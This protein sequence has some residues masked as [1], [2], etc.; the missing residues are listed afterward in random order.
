MSQSNFLVIMSDEHLATALGCANHP[1]V[2]TPNMDKLAARGVR[3]TNAYTPSPICV[4][5][6]AAFATGRRVHDI[7]YWDNAMAYDGRIKGWG[8]ALQKGGIPVES[9]GKLHYKGDA[10]D[11]GFDRKT[12]PMYV[13]GG[14]GMVWGSVR[15][16]HERRAMGGGMLGKNIGPGE[17]TY[18][19]YDTNVVRETQ[20]WMKVRSGATEPW[21]LYVGL[22]A[23]HFPLVVPQDFYD[24]YPHDTLPDAVLHPDRGYQPHP[25][26]VKQSDSFAVDR[27][28]DEDGLKKTAMAAY[29]GLITWLDYN[30]GLILEALDAAGFGENTTVVYTSDHGDNVGNR[31]LWGKSNLYDDAA[32]IPMIMAGPGIKA[33][34]CATPVDLLDLAKTIPH[35][36]GL[37]FEGET[38]ANP[39][40]EIASTPYDAKRSVMSEYHA[41]G[42]VGGGFM[43]RK[44]KWKLIRYV[45][46]DDELFD[47]EA[48]P[49]ET[50]NLVGNPE[51]AAI[52]E[53][54]LSDLAEI[55]D[56]E[57]VNAQAFADQDAM[58]ESYGGLEI[59]LTLGA[60][61][62]TPPPKP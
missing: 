21:C 54:L 4:P 55:C 52:H 22:V 14:H 32:A 24:I 16:E 62:A 2:R 29:Y 60:A 47:M 19:A 41:I 49:Q 5:T 56:I 9:I 48:D 37:D 39:L 7:R 30:L 59:A 36:F 18:T 11:D 46:F 3:F 23:P 40:T 42:A 34:I 31:G 35:H 8:H 51:V 43:L 33:G 1:F 6:R 50:S 57:A 10:F 44:G 28:L 26:I 58:I 20:D 12:V 45:G 13:V 27:K 53:E 17:S 61:A 38:T 25:W 15:R